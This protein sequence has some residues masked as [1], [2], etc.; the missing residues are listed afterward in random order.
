MKDQASAWHVPSTDR[1]DQSTE[2]LMIA[3]QGET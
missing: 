3:A 1:V 2:A